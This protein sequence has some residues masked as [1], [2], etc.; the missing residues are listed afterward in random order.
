MRCPTS[1]LLLFVGQSLYFLS[2]MNPM[3]NSQ[4]CNLQLSSVNRRD[5]CVRMKVSRALFAS[6]CSLTL[7]MLHRTFALKYMSHNPV[8]AYADLLSSWR[9]DVMGCRLCLLNRIAEV[10]VLS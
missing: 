10:V 2:G 3:T 1:L 9:C 8:S 7:L 4:N 6:G 5:Q